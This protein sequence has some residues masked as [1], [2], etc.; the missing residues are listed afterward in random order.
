MEELLLSV[1]LAAAIATIK[2]AQNVCLLLCLITTLLCASPVVL[3]VQFVAR[4]TR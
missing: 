4:T 3:A 1:L 2:S